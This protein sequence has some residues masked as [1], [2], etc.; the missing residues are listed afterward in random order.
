LSVSH[1]AD[2]TLQSTAIQSAVGVG[3]ANGVASLNGAGLVP[4]TQLGT[5]TPSS[6]NFLSGNGTWTVPAGGGTV[7]SVTAGDT[8]IVVGG[9]ANAPTVETA[10][11]DVIATDHPPAANWSNNSKKITNLENGSVASDAAA[12]GQ[13]PT[14]GTGITD[15]SGVLSV[16]YGT[17]SGTA[18]QGND[19]RITGALQSGATAGGD[20]TGTYPNPTLTNTTNVESIISN[21]STVTSKAPLA[22][23]ALTGTPTAPTAT[24][25]T[26]TTQIATTAF[27]ETAVTNGAAPNASSGTLGLIQ[28]DGDLGNTATLPEVVSTHLSSPLPTTQGGTGVNESTLAALLTALL[29]AGGGTMG[30]GL[31]PKV[32]TLTDASTVAI[33]AALSNDF[34]LTCTTGVGSTRALGAPT[35]PT[36]GQTIRID[37]IQPASGGPCALTFATGSG[38]YDFG[39]AGTFTSFS[40]AANAIDT[41]GFRYIATISKWTFLGSGLGF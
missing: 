27:V 13:I 35:N 36:D 8:S 11:L 34:R 1:N 25:G 30:A 39:T 38:G 9:S 17:T 40:T 33:N 24:S 16:T 3:S 41:L 4:L 12:F 29:A 28:L 31:A 2:G 23:P 18:A 26:N 15:T 6:S 22:S 7:T 32:T 37:V 20:L 14:A 19:S 21:N 10:T 5:G